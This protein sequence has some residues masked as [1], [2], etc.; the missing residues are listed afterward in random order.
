[1]PVICNIETNI[2]KLKQNTEIHNHSTCQKSN[3]IQFCGTDVLKKGIIDMEI[4]LFNKTPNQVQK[5]SFSS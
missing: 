2:E 5:T 4:K 3:H 1:M